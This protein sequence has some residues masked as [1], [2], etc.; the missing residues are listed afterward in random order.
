[1]SKRVVVDGYTLN[2]FRKGDSSV[3]I[4]IEEEIAIPFF[5]MDMLEVFFK[6]MLTYSGDDTNISIN[7]Q[8]ADKGVE[9][10][11]YFYNKYQDFDFSSHAENTFMALHTALSALFDLSICGG[12]NQA[13]IN[14]NAQ[15]ESDDDPYQDDEFLKNWLP[16][17]QQ[18]PS[19]GK[20][21]EMKKIVNKIL[22]NQEDLKD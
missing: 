22:E 1:M 10:V 12:I 9:I 20:L 5:Q 17:S 11:A 15:F 4:Y 16:G 8:R 3:I 2:T 13:S 14:E 6:R 21:N 18:P 19:N 7:V